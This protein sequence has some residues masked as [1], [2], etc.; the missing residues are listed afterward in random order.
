M[1]HNVPILFENI[2]DETLSWKHYFAV[3]NIEVIAEG[4]W[5][6]VVQLE[7]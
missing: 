3:E 1:Q 5:L 4:N 7:N 6:T 2:P